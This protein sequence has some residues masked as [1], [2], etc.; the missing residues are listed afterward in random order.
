MA[1]CTDSADGRGADEPDAATDAA[2]EDAAPLREVRLIDHSSWHNYPVE[3]DPLPDHQP[4]MI[5]C[6]LSGWFVEAGS[7]EV[8]T[9]NCNYLSIEHPAAEAV[10]AGTEIELELGHFDLLAPEPATAHVALLFE[11]ELQ[12]EDFIDIPG[13]GNL[14]RSRFRATRDLAAGESIRLHLHNHGQNTWLFGQ[15]IAFMP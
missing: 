3:L 11:S 1:A 15:V 9:A 10:P 7:L 6:G 14:E 2:E 5:K 8:D 4:A 12:W 13:P